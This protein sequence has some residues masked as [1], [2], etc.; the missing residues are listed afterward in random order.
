MGSFIEARIDVRELQR[1]AAGDPAASRALYEQLAGPCF[2]LVRRLVRDRAAAEDVFQEA[3][4][5]ILRGIGGFRGD[6]PLGAWARQVVVRCCLMHL[7]SPWQRT[8]HLLFGEDAAAGIAA[9]EAAPAE[10]LDLM[11][12]LSRLSP[13]A[14]AVVWLHDVEGLTHAEIASA[15]GRSPGFSKSRLSRAH[16]QLRSHLCGKEDPG[17]KALDNLSAPPA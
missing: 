7:R 4:L 10:L 16:A 2:T 17:C 13:V 15:F 1:V 12:A 9:G 5:A 11:Q 3:M 14:R 6:A 8:R